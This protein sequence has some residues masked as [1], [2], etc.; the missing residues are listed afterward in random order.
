MARLH[1]SFN[2]ADSATLGPGLAWTKTAGNFSVSTYAIRPGG[3]TDTFAVPTAATVGT[4]DVYCQA[5]IEAI[6]TG[7]VGVGLRATTANQSGIYFVV[8]DDPTNTYRLFSR[9]TGGAWTQ[10]G[11][12]VAGVIPSTPF[13]IRI[14][15]EGDNF[16]G[17]VNGSTV[18]SGSSSLFN[19][20]DKP[21]V[22]ANTAN[23]R[24]AFFDAGDLYPTLEYSTLVQRTGATTSVPVSGYYV[25]GSADSVECRVL[26]DADDSTVVDWTEVDASPSG[27]QWSGII[28]VPTGG[29]YYIEQRVLDSGSST[30]ES[31]SGTD[32]FIVGDIIVAAGQSNTQGRGT[33][34][35]TYAGTEAAWLYRDDDLLDET[36]SDP[37][38]N[39]TSAG[40]SWGPLLATLIEADQGVPVAFITNAEGGTGLGPDDPDWLPPSS[41]LWTVL[42]DSLDYINP[43]AIKAFL[44]LQGERDAAVETTKSEYVSAE[45]TLATAVNAL[46]GSPELISSLIGHNTSLVSASQLDPIRDAKIANWNSGVSLPGANPIDIDLS[47]ESGDGLHFKTN[48]ELATLAGR[49]WLALEDA[50]YSGSN[51]RGPRIS[52]VTGKGT[53]ELTVL[54]D[55]DLDTSDTTYTS[56]LFTVDNDDGTART[57]SSATRTGTRAVTL[58]LSGDLDGTDPTLTFAAGNTAAGSTMPKTEPIDLPATINSISSVALPAEPAFAVSVTQ[59][60][61]YDDSLGNLFFFPVGA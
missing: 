22:Y 36:L 52:A 9:S 57:V 61:A 2:K 21:A 35:Q 58:A 30:L 47:N 1:D 10:I 56:T 16:V 60:S 39:G 7:N 17:K 31:T 33:S 6:S 37:W 45:T 34:N 25:D 44:W 27:N 4:D 38:S 14:E 15:M 18:I 5:E 43:T 24:I 46:P 12:S 11:S 32:R 48:A 55:R 49:I 42:S 19:T 26:L 59:A 20:S 29:P 51:G 50:V 8:R 54:F 13:S 28:T 23:E 40:G 41:R 3:A 53:S